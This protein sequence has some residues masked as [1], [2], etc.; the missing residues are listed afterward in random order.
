MY[1]KG[2]KIVEY[3]LLL[4]GAALAVFGFIY[5]FDVNNAIATDVLLYWAYAVVVIGVVL[6]AVLG[7]AIAAK[8][9][10]KGLL[11]GGIIIVAA[12]AIVA[13]AY[14][15]APGAEAVGIAGQ[16]PEGNVLKLTDTVLNLT[17]LAI[18][19]AIIAL[20]AGAIINAVRK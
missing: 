11:R 2:I 14:V 10:P 5:G 13:I 15:V 1:A 20:I 18:G 3:V 7:I 9:N 4:L 17:Y 12:A 8:N 19:A 6:I 16:Q